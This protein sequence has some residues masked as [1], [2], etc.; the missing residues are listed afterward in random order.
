[1]PHWANFD[2]FISAHSYVSC[3]AKPSKLVQFAL[4]QGC[5]VND[6]G[7]R[8][9][10]GSPGQMGHCFFGSLFLPGYRVRPPDLKSCLVLQVRLNFRLVLSCATCLVLPW[11]TPLVDRVSFIH[12]KW[13]KIDTVCPISKAEFLKNL[14]RVPGRRVTTLTGSRP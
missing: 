5:I 9:G 7:I 12:A 2:D 6:T 14:Y 10:S 13:S 11:F 8:D 3:F 4:A 1:M